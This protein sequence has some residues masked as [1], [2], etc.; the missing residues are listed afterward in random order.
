MNLREIERIHK[1]IKQAFENKLSTLN[2]EVGQ[3]ILVY[4]FVE[5]KGESLISGRTKTK[6]SLKKGFSIPATIKK[7]FKSSLQ[8]TINKESQI[9]RAK[10]PKD[11]DYKV[12]I[13][14]IQLISEK[15][16]IDLVTRNFYLAL[17]QEDFMYNEINIIWDNLFAESK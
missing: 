4:N 1:N 13:S 3:K 5:I 10:V 2:F 9:I 14:L 8:V 7:T 17:W 16:W 11:K 12:G 6:V 15:D